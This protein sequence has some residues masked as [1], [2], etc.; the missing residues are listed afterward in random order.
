MFLASVLLEEVLHFASCR[1]GRI[2]TPDEKKLK[3]KSFEL[4][5]TPNLRSLDLSIGQSKDISYILNLA[6]LRCLVSDL[7]NFTEFMI[8]R[9]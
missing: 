9:L 7:R 2:F 8:I 1:L 4:L 6:S 3:K 5:I